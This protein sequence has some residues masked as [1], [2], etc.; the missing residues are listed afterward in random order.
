MAM[1]EQPSLIPKL[2]KVLAHAPYLPRTLSLVWQ[3][4]GK[5]SIAWAGLLLIQGLVPVA[6][7]YL[8]KALTNHLVA[9]LKSRG[10]WEDVRPTLLFMALMAGL[11]LAGELLRAGAELVR[12]L[13]SELVQEHITALIQHKAA[14][15]DIAYYDLPEYYDHLDMARIEAQ[16]RP[17]ALLEGLGSLVQNGIT[18]A[19]MAGI[20]IPFGWWL[21]FA[22]LLS[23]LPAFS[24]VSRFAVREYEWTLLHKRDQRL[25]RHYDWVL[26]SRDSAAELRLFDLG[27]YF[28]SAYHAVRQRVRE[29]H[30]RLTWL[31]SGAQLAAGACGLLISGGAMAWMALRAIRG[32]ATAGDLALLYQTFNQ[33][34]RPMRTLLDRTALLYSDILVLGSLFEFLDLELGV[35]DPAH[36]V[37]APPIV[38]E[39]IRFRQVT[40]RYQGNPRPV[41]KNFNLFLPAGRMVALVGA[42]G[43][44]K[45]TL[46][47]LLCRFYDPEAGS[48]ELDD[49][50]F[51]RLRVG[52][53]RRMITVVF[54]Q[55]IC[56]HATVRDNIAVGDWEAR[57][58]TEAITEAARAAGV[59]RIID[60]LPHGYDT[61][62]GKEFTEGT[63]LSVG[64]WQRLALARA[65]VRRCPI[66]VLDEPTSAMDPWAEAEWLQKFRRR[67]AGQTVLLITHRFSTAVFADF[68][69]VISEGQIVESGSHAELLERGGRYAEA[70]RAHE[71]FRQVSDSDP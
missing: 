22:L 53:L 64:E 52:E 62:L 20:L 37:A 56:Y 46:I 17:V 48:I 66:V 7:V 69:H 35:V 55:P 31:Q 34:L 24:V 5:L 2:R 10:A 3:A 26:T 58:G 38:R 50:D 63:D 1:E 32:Q 33:G 43:A 45:S 13:Q 27:D 9:A 57:P 36:P 28:R 71:Q 54:Q 25:A 19:A 8:T 42:N 12:T 4:A 44:G 14:A 40:F 11:L 49:T 21:P 68:I 39:G 23:T 61:K 29:G 59:D 67:T 51:R 60:R 18:V 65:C 15:I 16:K 6:L 30:I 41:L 70:W 47:K